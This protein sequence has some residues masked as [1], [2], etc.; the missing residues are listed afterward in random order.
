MSELSGAIRHVHDNMLCKFTLIFATD[1]NTTLVQDSDGIVGSFTMLRPVSHTLSEVQRLMAFFSEY[2]VI[3]GNT[4]TPNSPEDVEQ[5]YTWCRGGSRTQIDYIFHDS[6]VWEGYTKVVPINRNP[7]QYSDHRVVVACLR[8]FP[9]FRANF[10]DC[11]VRTAVQSW[12]G[13]WPKTSGDLK[14]YQQAALGLVETSDLSQF[15]QRMVDIAGDVNFHTASSLRKIQRTR[16]NHDVKVSRRL[17]SNCS[18]HGS[19]SEDGKRSAVHQL[20]VARRQRCKRKASRNLLQLFKGETVKPPKVPQRLRIG[21]DFSVNREEWRRHGQS[22]GSN[23]FGDPNNSLQSQMARMTHLASIQ[24]D[25]K[26]DGLRRCGIDCFDTFAARSEMKTMK[27]SGRD[28]LVG[29]CFR[30][31]P[32]VAVVKAW[33]LFDGY[34]GNFGANSP[35]S[36]DV[37]PHAGLRKSLVANSLDQYRWLGKLSSLFRWYCRSWKAKL[38]DHTK[39]SPVNT[40][41]FTR[42]CSA[43]DVVAQLSEAVRKRADDCKPLIIISGDIETA[44]DEMHHNHLDNA[45][46]AKKVDIHTRIELMKQLFNKRATLLIPGA[47]E[48]DEFAY[49]KGG[50]QGGINTPDEFNCMIQHYLADEVD[51][52]N[53]FGYGMSIEDE[54]V[55]FNHVFFA[56]NGFFAADS[57][58]DGAHMFQEVTANLY[59]I[60]FKWKA[61][62]HV[63]WCAPRKDCGLGS[64]CA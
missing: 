33:R 36:W 62:Y 42:G 54:G 21:A 34:F 11:K 47:G 28:P 48:T 29:E 9:A 23:T 63:G 3:A 7:F 27:A 53:A 45:L 57:V 61:S 55:V 17:V 38:R 51:S 19:A 60:G 12:V 49:N 1:L 64:V 4:H 30:L 18:I 8:S 16:E 6:S 52:W 56:D 41:G 20:R 13:W 50:W 2:K 32:Y 24:Q 25:H 35:E 59:K 15:Q 31:L 5:L 40:V 14:L 22:C 43:Q 10:G 58:E 26:L 46:A 39:R 37:V 44:F